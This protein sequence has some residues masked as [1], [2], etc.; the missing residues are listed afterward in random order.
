MEEQ[1]TFTH[2]DLRPEPQ[3]VSQN[4]PEPI[5]PSSHVA[6]PAPL[7]SEDRVEDAYTHKPAPSADSFQPAVPSVPSTNGLTSTSIP[8]KVEL[9]SVVQK[10]E[11]SLSKQIQRDLKRKL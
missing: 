10:D 8:S 9:P 4:F 1:P 2:P 11:P 7:A 5:Q 3:S 6:Q